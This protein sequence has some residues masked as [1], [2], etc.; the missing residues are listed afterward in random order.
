MPDYGIYAPYIYAA[1]GLSA[2][3]LIALIVYVKL[4]SKDG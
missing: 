2:A 4:R 1:Y 3:V